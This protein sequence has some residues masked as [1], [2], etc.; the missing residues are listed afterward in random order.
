MYGKTSIYLDKETPY[1]Y[2]HCESND[3]S[4]NINYSH[5]KHINYF[6]IY[7]S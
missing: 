7:N 6:I 3:N 1:N 5:E 4:I 2:I